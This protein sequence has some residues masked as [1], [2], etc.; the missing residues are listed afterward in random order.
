MGK[1]QGEA[2]R[3]KGNAK[4]SSSAKAAEM[5]SQIPNY[6]FGTDMPPIGIGTLME[7]SFDSNIDSDF[8]MV[9]KKL[10]KKDTLTKIK[11]LEELKNLIDTKSQED[12]VNIVPYWAKSYTKLSIVS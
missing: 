4:P 11:T 3:V 12:C 9:L 10:S 2:A 7:D 1:K 8:R 6:S 5:L